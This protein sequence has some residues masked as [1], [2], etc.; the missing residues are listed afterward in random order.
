MISAVFRRGGNVDFVGEELKAV[1][2]P[3]GGAWVKGRYV[4]SLLAAIGGVVETHLAATKSGES[5]S[6]GS[7]VGAM[8]THDPYPVYRPNP[9]AT[10]SS[11]SDG[12][13]SQ[14]AMC[15]QCGAVPLVRKEGCNMCLDCGY[16]KC[17]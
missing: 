10:S 11:R 15:P 9:T 3:Q 8:P 7:R 16:S 5:V 17:D 6:L 14:M 2:D 12:G 4:P 1:F 13:R